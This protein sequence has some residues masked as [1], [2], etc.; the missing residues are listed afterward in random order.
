MSIQF[1]IP[2]VPVA[3]GSK[4]AFVV[5]K[6][7]VIVD[8]NKDKIRDF[9]ATVSDVAAPYVGRF[10]KDTAVF[11]EATFYL[12]RPKSVRR[13]HPTVAPDSDKLD[14]ALRDALTVAGVWADDAQV[15]KA[16]ILKEYAAK[17]GVH[18]TLVELA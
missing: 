2:A 1:F 16:H 6:R 5:G 8:T 15:V 7:A 12:P 14:R 17:P 9:R 10:P 4:R 3:Q 18:V 11:L 13:K